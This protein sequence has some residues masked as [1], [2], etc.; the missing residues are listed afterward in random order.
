MYEAAKLE[1]AKVIADAEGTA[2]ELPDVD[3]LRAAWVELGPEQKLLAVAA[4]I[5]RAVLHPASRGERV[6]INW[7]A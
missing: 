6:E 1:Q 4:L 7:R 2:V 3:D 5:D